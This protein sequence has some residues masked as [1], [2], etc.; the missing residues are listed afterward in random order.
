MA[1]Q[2]IQLKESVLREMTR[3]VILEAL[4]NGELDEGFLRNMFG[5]LKNAAQSTGQAIAQRGNKFMADYN[6]GAAQSAKQDIEKQIQ[7][8]QE[9]IKKEQEKINTLRAKYN[10]YAQNADKY[11][12]KANQNAA[13]RGSNTRYSGYGL[14]QDTNSQD[15]YNQ[16]DMDRSNFS[17]RMRGAQQA[18][19]KM[20]KRQQPQTSENPRKRMQMPNKPQTAVSESVDLKNIIR[21]AISNV[22]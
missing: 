13:N 22:L 3:S 9:V 19:N 11:T 16:S 8:S 1:T 20:R 15:F 5:G 4:A 2:K 6:A 7:K 14:S 17:S 12:D 18:H 10:Q 21:E